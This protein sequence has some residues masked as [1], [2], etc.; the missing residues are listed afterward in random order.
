MDHPH[1]VVGPYEKLPNPTN[2]AIVHIT[3]L[4]VDS[5]PSGGAI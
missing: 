3:L 1:R 4:V 2:V 5:G